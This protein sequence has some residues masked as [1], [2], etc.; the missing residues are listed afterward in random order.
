MRN[1]EGAKTVLEENRCPICASKRVYRYMKGIFDCDKT[2]VW[3]CRECEVQF[4]DTIMNMKEEE[5]YY[6]DYYRSQHNRYTDKL[7][8]DE[9]QSRSYDYFLE[10]QSNYSSYIRNS[11]RILEV[12]CGSGGFLKLLQ[13]L[14]DKQEV[15][16]VERSETNLAFL[17]KSF[18]GYCFLHNIS[19]AQGRQ[20]DLIVGIA[21]FEHLRAPLR[22]L[23]YLKKLL[24]E[25]GHII[26]EMPNK[27]DALIEIYELSEF[28]RFNYQKQH[29]FTYSEKPLRI[30]AKEAGL[31]VQKVYYSQQ[32]GLDNHISWLK[33]RQA[34]D[35]S[36]YSDVFSAETLKS[37]KHDLA[38]LKCTDVIG[39]V[40]RK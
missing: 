29:Y 10:H 7:E 24:E 37:Y 25:E 17:R 21:V 32:Y 18:P 39:V 40:L 16:G 15:V 2:E 27:A 35:Y 28:K 34:G 8:I 36:Q 31:T 3:E 9:V 5:A 23:L 14:F 33:N 12:G 1:R 4:L 38:R 11:S 19:E 13:S 22:F 30:L 26:L 6:K 20:F